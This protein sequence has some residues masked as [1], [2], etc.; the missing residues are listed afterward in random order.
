MPPP[1]AMTKVCV[2]GGSGYIGSSLVKRLL[3]KGYV[4]HATLRNL[5]DNSRVD[6]LKSLPGAETR[7]VLFQVDINY[8]PDD[9]FQAAIQGCRYVL[10]VATPQQIES[11]GSKYKDMTEAAVAGVKSIADT[12]IRSGTV[13]RLIYTASALSTSPMKEDGSGYKPYMDESCWTSLN[14]SFPYSSDY[15]LAY[16]RS[17]TI[18]EKEILS[19]NDKKNCSIEIVTLACGLVG[20]E[21]VLPFAP[22]SVQTMASPLTRNKDVYTYGLMFMQGVLGTVPIV[23]IKDVCE[24]HIFCM[25]RESIK[26]RFICAA[27]DLTV[28]E[29]AMFYQKKYP[30]IKIDNGF[31]GEG[32]ERGSRCDSSKL[33]DLGFEY[34]LHDAEG[35]LEDNDDTMLRLNSFRLSRRIERSGCREVVLC[36]RRRVGVVQGVIFP[37]DPWAPNID[38]QS[39]ASQLFAVSLFPY[40]GF[41]YFITKS[42]SVPRLT[43]FGFYFLLAFVGATIP[44]GIYAK[45]HY[46][47]SLSNVD[48]LHGGA[49][50]L[51][52][53]TNL[54]IV[55]GLRGALKKVKNENMASKLNEEKNPPVKR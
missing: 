21:T 5:K 41:L 45:V 27:T 39:I 1:V 18:T 7:L 6:L 54:F 33:K 12:C 30:E 32:A 34:K 37:V 46:G 11:P 23:H 43:L 31:M 10:H 29:I 26:G 14:I 15:T 49:E 4:V 44:A 51:L 2:T 47:T 38:S 42:K 20:G 28:A 17:K 35:I 22:L 55:L 48:W 9:E 3:E 53:L 36:G 13:K 25:E 40:I 8:S 19:Y 52:T 50:F 24:A 16:T